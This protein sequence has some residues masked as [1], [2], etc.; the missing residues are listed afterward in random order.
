[1]PR[2]YPHFLDSARRYFT[3]R[4]SY[5]HRC[6]I[7]TP[8]GIV[9]PTLFSQHD[10]ITV[11]EAFCRED[12]A[13]GPDARVV[14]D[15]GS[16]IGIS[17]LYFLTRSPDARVWLHE[18][19]PENA[20]RLRRNLAGFK[21]WRLDQVAVADR[22]GEESFSVEASG[23]YGALDDRHAESIRVS[24]RHIDDVLQ[25]VLAS[26]EWIDVLKIDTEGTEASI[27]R[28][29][30]PELLAR[31]GVI[32][33]EDIDREVGGLPGFSASRRASVLRLRARR[34]TRSARRSDPR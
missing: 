31:V 20:E 14:V 7:R 10:M 34:P 13:A 6:E 23:R 24:V 28:A 18:P 29:A 21:A 17:A 27:L 5:P 33:V 22:A 15:V 32:Y 9:A 1:M 25:D 2:R 12:Y 11:N 19:V 8:Q 16:N 26:E 4:G 3:A 30:S